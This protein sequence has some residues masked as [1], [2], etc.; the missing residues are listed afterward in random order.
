LVLSGVADGA[1]AARRAIGF[2]NAQATVQGQ[3]VKGVAKY[4]AADT[5]DVAIIAAG[6]VVVEAGAAIAVGDSLIVDTQGR[7]I[8][9]T[10]GLTVKT[11]AV[12][13]TSTAANGAVLAGG[14][15]PEFVFADA[16]QAASAAGQF[17]E[18]LL[19]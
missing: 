1:I 6:V 13:V 9:S 2:D 8:P 16:L 10:G 12:A 3:K 4:A 18:A 14:D 7:A 11:G 19:R 5:K 15:A 17:V